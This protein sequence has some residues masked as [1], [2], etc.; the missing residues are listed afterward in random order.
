MSP[1]GFLPQ[2][3]D[4]LTLQNDQINS[5]LHAIIT[6]V[7]ELNQQCSGYTCSWKLYRCGVS[8]IPG[9]FTPTQAK[10]VFHESCCAG[11]PARPPSDWSASAHVQLEAGLE[12]AAEASVGQWDRRPPPPPAWHHIAAVARW[13][14]CSESAPPHQNQSS[15]VLQKYR[16][17]AKPALNKLHNVSLSE[18]NIQQTLPLKHLNSK[19]YIIHLPN[20]FAFHSFTIKDFHTCAIMQGTNSYNNLHYNT[21]GTKHF[22]IDSY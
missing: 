14:L 10:I 15:A 2:A 19:L 11:L 5:T 13:A 17:A 16:V 9:T 4:I 6:S 12:A 1:L 7:T 22:L 8:N 18:I 3:A 20:H 21:F